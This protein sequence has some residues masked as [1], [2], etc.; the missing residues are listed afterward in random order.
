MT[1]DFT[2]A[3]RA[4][5]ASGWRRRPDDDIRED[6]CQNADGTVRLGWDDKH[7]CLWRRESAGVRWPAY[8][9]VLPVESAEQAVDLLVALDV[10]PPELSSTYRLGW[11]EAMHQHLVGAP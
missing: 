1:P 2:G 5:L 10:L 6:T 7:I 4:A 8:A 11:H 9:L 3:V